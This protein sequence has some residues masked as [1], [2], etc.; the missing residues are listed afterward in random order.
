M[1]VAGYPRLPALPSALPRMVVTKGVAS[2][3][4]DSEGAAATITVDACVAGGHSGGPVVSATTGQLIGLVSS[5]AEVKVECL[6]RRRARD[7]S[8][9]RDSRCCTSFSFLGRWHADSFMVGAVHSRLRG[10]TS[11]L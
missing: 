7:A 3:A 5:Y 6:V 8:P 10:T 2:V 11:P 9:L 4:G 1:L